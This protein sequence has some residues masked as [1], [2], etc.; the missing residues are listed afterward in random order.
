MGQQRS[1]C[2]DQL[3]PPSFETLLLMDQQVKEMTLEMR[4]IRCEQARRLAGHDCDDVQ[5]ALIHIPLASI[6]D[7]A[8]RQRLLALPTS[9]T[10]PDADVDALVDQGRTLITSNPTLLGLLA[11]FTPASAPAVAANERAGGKAD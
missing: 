10:L 3:N 2:D 7:E 1:C 11:D 6:A 4:R 9:L 8:T 5:G